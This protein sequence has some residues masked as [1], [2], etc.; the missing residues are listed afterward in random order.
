MTVASTTPKYQIPFTDLTDTVASAATTMASLAAR[1][2][3]LLG[4]SGV[5]NPSL[6]AN[7]PATT[8]ITLSRTYPGN[9]GGSTPGIVIVQRMNAFAS[10]NAQHYWVVA[11]TGTA[12]TVTGFT[13]GT[14]STQTHSPTL[15]WRFL[16]IL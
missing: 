15:V 14:I 3:L 16:P 2:D 9:A 6:T 7:T 5:W 4:E 10:G 12:T 1:M 13:L 8:V 11:F